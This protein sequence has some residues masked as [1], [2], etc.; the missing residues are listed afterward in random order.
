MRRR[1]SVIGGHSPPVRLNFM[2]GRKNGTEI[3]FDGLAAGLRSQAA[4][5][6]IP[7]GLINQ[8]KMACERFC[9]SNGF[10]V[11]HGRSWIKPSL[12]LFTAGLWCLPLRGA[13][14]TNTIAIRD[15]ATAAGFHSM[16]YKPECRPGTPGA[17]P[18][19]C[20]HPRCDWRAMF[21]RSAVRKFGQWSENRGGPDTAS[22]RLIRNRLAGAFYS[23]PSFV[24]PGF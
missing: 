20:V 1:N 2:Q 11:W 17:L 22:T 10:L 18:E 13:T 9:P 21:A 23:P 24:F 16:G 7:F 15:A 3:A 4:V 6:L 19:A 12:I 8:L 5:R 14:D